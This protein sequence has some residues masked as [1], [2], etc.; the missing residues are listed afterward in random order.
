MSRLKVYGHVLHRPLNLAAPR[1]A[2]AWSPYS[3]S[4]VG[5]LK[6]E[7]TA[8]CLTANS[9]MA[10]LDTWPQYCRTPPPLDQCVSATGWPAGKAPGP[11]QGAAKRAEDVLNWRRP[12]TV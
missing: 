1:L 7:S 5:G 10:S 4:G 3:E 9:P 12:F 11:A 2:A 8:G 6:G